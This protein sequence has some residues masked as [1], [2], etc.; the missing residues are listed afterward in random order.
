MENNMFD[1]NTNICSDDCWKNAKE[2]NN[3]KIE[4]YNIY[5]TNLVACESPFVRMTDMYLN[6][7][8]LR[9]RPGYGLA[10]DCLIDKY[11]ALSYD[12]G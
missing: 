9:G 4:G 11:S 8:N 12:S 5:P 7:P 1:T 2:V 10:D 6:H 3:S